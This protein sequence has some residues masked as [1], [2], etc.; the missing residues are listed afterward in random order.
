MVVYALGKNPKKAKEI[1]AITDPV[2]F[3]FAVAKLEKELKV[4]NRRAAPPPERT[5]QA[6]GRVSGTVD[7][8]RER[9]RPEA[10]KT[11]DY[12]KVFRYKRQLAAKSN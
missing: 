7:S 10:E 4:T 9:L 8:T 2:K 12:S 5:V 6:T 3:A 11:G 1:A